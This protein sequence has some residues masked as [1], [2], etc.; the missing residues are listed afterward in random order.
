MA[1]SRKEH[2]QYIRQANI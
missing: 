1:S 2:S